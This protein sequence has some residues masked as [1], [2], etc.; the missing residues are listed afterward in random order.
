MRIRDLF[1]EKIFTLSN[2]FTVLRVLTVPF[3]GYFLYRE[4]VSGDNVYRYYE[5]ICFLIIVL[6]DF[7]DG[8]FARLLNQV[9][10]FG[11]FLDPVADK[12]TAISV[13]ILLIIY[14]DFPIWVFSL[15]LIREIVIF[16]FGIVFYIKKDVDVKPNIFGKI[17]ANSLAFAAVV[18][19][20]SLDYSVWTITI[21][22]ISIFLI[23]LFYTLAI[24]LYVKTYHKGLFDKKESNH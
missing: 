21:K 5:M 4:H 17:Y 20:L 3:L 24:L 11:Q 10:R 6:S 23:L 16:I 15:A 13:G 8:F 18:Y 22:E 14:K 19:T 9:S 7:L 1:Q 12:I 2:G